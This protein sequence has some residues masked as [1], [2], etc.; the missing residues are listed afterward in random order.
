MRMIPFRRP[1]RVV[2]ELE[3]MA[4]ANGK[5]IARLNASKASLDPPGRNEN[6]ENQKGSNHMRNSPLSVFVDDFWIYVA[7]T[8]HGGA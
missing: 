2:R 4:A 3:Y 5:F 7:S 8:V 6:R 1:D